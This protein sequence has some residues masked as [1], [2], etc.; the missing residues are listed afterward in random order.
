MDR[1]VFLPKLTAAL[2]RPAGSLTERSPLDSDGW[3]SVDLLNVIALIDEDL[4]L[5]VS[6]DDFKLCR[7]VGDLL[8]YLEGEQASSGQAG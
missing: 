3:D 7:T 4:G 2:E 5:T 6:G 1:G 8:T